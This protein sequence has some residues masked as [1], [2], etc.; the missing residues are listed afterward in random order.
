MDLIGYVDRKCNLRSALAL[1]EAVYQQGKAENKDGLVPDKELRRVAL[2]TAR[3]MVDRAAQP[4]LR[5][6]KGYW[7]A[8]GGAFGALGNFFYMFKSEV[9]GKLGLY[10]AQMMAG[11]HGAWIM[12]ALSFGVLNSL[13]L[14]LIDWIGGRWYDDDE[15]KWAKRG[16]KFAANVVLNDISSVP[17]IGAAMDD[18]RSALLG[19]W[20]PEGSQLVDMVMPFGDIWN[21]GKREW[22]NAENGA[23]WD[24]HVAALCGLARG[25]GALG[26]WG[27]NVGS[28][29]VGSAAELALAAAAVSNTVRAAKDMLKKVLEELE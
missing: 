18:A 24:K 25:V 16:K 26:G 11:R 12:G 9:L 10:V 2:E 3:M 5:T 17:V 13:V 4:Q 20:R 15:D 1:A 8:G 19:E 14:A 27:Q 21:Y 28:A 22:K 7:A 6:Q 23:G 29:A